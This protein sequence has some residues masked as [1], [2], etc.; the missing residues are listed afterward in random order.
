MRTYPNVP[1]TNM[2]NSTQP[3]MRPVHVWSQDID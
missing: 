3:A 1:V 2:K